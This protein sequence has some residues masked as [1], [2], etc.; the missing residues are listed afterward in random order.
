MTISQTRFF[1]A[2]VDRLPAGLE[3]VN[4]ALKN[5]PFTGEEDNASRASMYSWFDHQ[6][7][8]DSQVEAF[9]NQLL[10]GTYAFC[11]V[12]IAVTPGSFTA[13]AATAEEMYSPEVYGRTNSLEVVV[14]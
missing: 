13:P 6:N 7:I 2:L 3:P 1:V 9:A 11:Y 8:R 12:A 4:F 10:P 14:E 5:A